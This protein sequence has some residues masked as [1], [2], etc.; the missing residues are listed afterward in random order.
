M[1]AEPSS[2][3]LAARAALDAVVLPVREQV[4]ALSS[5][6]TDPAGTVRQAADTVRAMAKLAPR[7]GD[8]IFAERAHRPAA[9]LHNNL[10]PGIAG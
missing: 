9:A 2:A 6:V 5:A 3:E 10:C 1:N 8:G 4:L 7:G